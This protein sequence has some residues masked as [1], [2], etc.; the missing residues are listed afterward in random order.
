MNARRRKT[1][2]VLAMLT[3]LASLVLGCIEPE[4]GLEA[5]PS[6]MPAEETPSVQVTDAPPSGSAVPIEMEY[7][8][9]AGKEEDY[10]LH[11]LILPTGGRSA[12]E[13]SQL[14][15]FEIRFLLPNGWTIVTDEADDALLKK[16]RT[17]T[18]QLYQA[19]AFFDGEE[20][21]AATLGFSAY[22]PKLTA[23]HDYKRI[24]A[25]LAS[26]ER[27]Y[28]IESACRPF[29]SSAASNMT[30]L[31][32]VRSGI[33]DGAVSYSPAVIAIDP[34]RGVYVAVEFAASRVN[35]LELMDFAESL[36]VY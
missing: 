12:E 22:D 31:C 4:G 29:Y 26:G 33:D 7:A 2:A 9:P 32:Q 10:T 14:E 18:E 5:T 24:L 25:P 27:A 35:A 19:A 23:E 28:L 11:S 13:L 1:L 34:E 6:P 30:M 8:V 16:S 36:C 15:P 3:A 20:V 21:L 17:A